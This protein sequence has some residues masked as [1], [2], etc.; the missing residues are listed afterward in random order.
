MKMHFANNRM[1]V[2]GGGGANPSLILVI[3]IAAAEQAVTTL[4]R[5]WSGESPPDTESIDERSGCMDGRGGSGVGRGWV[6]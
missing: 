4:V 6:E 5:P 2:C 1:C 3:I